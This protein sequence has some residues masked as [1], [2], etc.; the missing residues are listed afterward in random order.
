MEKKTLLCQCPL[1]QRIYHQCP[2]KDSILNKCQPKRLTNG[3][4]TIPVPH[5]QLPAIPYQQGIPG[6]LSLCHLTTLILYLT[7]EPCQDMKKIL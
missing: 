6:P 7:E 3:F 2:W 1:C 5:Q 4:K